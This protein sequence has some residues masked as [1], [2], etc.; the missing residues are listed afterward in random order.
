[1]YPPRS[2]WW[3]KQDRLILKGTELNILQPW[4]PLSPTHKL[5][6]VLLANRVFSMSAEKLLSLAWCVKLTTPYFCFP[7]KLTTSKVCEKSASGGLCIVG[8]ICWEFATRPKMI[9][10]IVKQTEIACVSQI[11]IICEQQWAFPA[12]RNAI[13]YRLQQGSKTLKR[14]TWVF[15]QY[16]F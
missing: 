7:S 9:H 16:G 2:K 3:D 10:K 14:Q 13:P 8:K 6:S 4:T 11:L 12:P 1:M 15:R 5:S